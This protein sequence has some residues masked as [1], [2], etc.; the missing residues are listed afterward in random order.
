VSFV[1]TAVAAVAAS[2]SGRQLYGL[3]ASMLRVLVR[4]HEQRQAARLAAHV[5]T[6]GG[7]VDCHVRGPGLD[8][9][10]SSQRRGRGRGGAAGE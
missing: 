5:L 3:L 9:R 10:I 7:D 4:L 8:I 6:H 2:L 1:V